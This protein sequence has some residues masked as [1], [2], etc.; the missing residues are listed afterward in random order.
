MQIS[1]KKYQHCQNWLVVGQNDVQLKYE[2]GK[3][4]DLLIINI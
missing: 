1:I 3:K 2:N 4:I